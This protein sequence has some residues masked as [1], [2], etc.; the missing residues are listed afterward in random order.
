MHKC[1]YTFGGILRWVHKHHEILRWLILLNKIV[2]VNSEDNFLFRFLAN[3]DFCVQWHYDILETRWLKRWSCR[4]AFE[5]R[6]GHQLSWLRF[7]VVSLSPSVQTPVWYNKLSYGHFIPCPVQFIASSELQTKQA[8]VRTRTRPRLQYSPGFW[9]LY[10]AVV[11]LYRRMWATASMSAGHC[12]S[13][14]VS[15]ALGLQGDLP[16]YPSHAGLCNGWHLFRGFNNRLTVLESEDCV[17]SWDQW[18]GLCSRIGERLRPAG[19]PHCQSQCRP[20]VGHRKQ[21]F[22]SVCLQ[23][24]CIRRAPWVLLVSAVRWGPL[25]WMIKK[26]GMWRT[27]VQLWVLEANGGCRPKSRYIY[28]Y[29][30][31]NF[32]FWEY[33][34]PRKVSGPLC[35]I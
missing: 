8:R 5:S 13:R 31:T 3:V 27:P 9:V 1:Y 29:H 12:R 21:I 7:L 34:L 33:L 4:L 18:W 14:V 6:L 30:N 20:L 35:Y 2:D 28:T 24:M 25:N 15:G 11:V 17:S 19:I 26:E 16:L 23:S 22:F 10:T 32:T